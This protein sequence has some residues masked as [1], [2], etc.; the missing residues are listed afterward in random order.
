L[1][2]LAALRRAAE[3]IGDPDRDHLTF[4][5]SGPPEVRALATAL[6]LMLARVGESGAETERALEATRRFAGD[7][8]HELRTPLAAMG[9]DLAVLGDYATAAPPVVREAIA[10]LNGAQQQLTARV[11]SLQLLTLGDAGRSLPRTEI[12]LA[13]LAEESVRAA[14]RRHAGRD[15]RLDPSAEVATIHGWPDG[16]CAIVDNLVE[17]AL[18]HAGPAAAVHVAV[19]ATNEHILLHVDDNGRGVPPTD[20]DRIFERF[21][22][23]RDAAP[24]G[25]GLGLSIVAQQ[26][27]L[28]DGTVTVGPSPLGGARFTVRLPRKH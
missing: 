2:P 21:A 20:R 16:L 11:Q 17:N 18:R 24:G 27:Q 1:R 6:R 15:V 9:A 7:A 25:S 22:R 19:L 12:D 28:H 14:R 10:S 13:D 4:A 3:G 8:G 23:G 26:T 5:A